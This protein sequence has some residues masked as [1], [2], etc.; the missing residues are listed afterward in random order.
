MVNYPKGSNAFSIADLY[1]VLA[2]TSHCC[3][4]HVY[5]LDNSEE[6]KCS[7]KKFQFPFHNSKDGIDSSYKYEVH[8][9]HSRLVIGQITKLCWVCLLS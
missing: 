4:P 3:A 1:V 7:F 9:F 5:I 8:V 2:R 6:K